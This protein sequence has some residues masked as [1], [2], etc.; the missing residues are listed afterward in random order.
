MR[1]H[2][3][4]L[5]FLILQCA[6]CFPA[7]YAQQIQKIFVNPK[8]PAVLKQSAFIDSVMLVPFE[9]VDGLRAETVEVRETKD[10]FMLFDF[11]L[12]CLYIFS[13]TGAFVK[14][15]NFKTTVGEAYPHYNRQTNQVVFFTTNGHYTLTARDKIKILL[16]WDNKRNL[17]YYNKYLIDLGDSSFPI[18]KTKPDKFDLVDGEPIFDHDFFQTQ[19]STSP[20]FKDS[21]G[22]EVSVYRNGTLHKNYFPYNRVNEPAFLFYEEWV[23]VS[24]AAPNSA[25]IARPYRDTIYRL[26]NDSLYPVYQVVLPLENSIPS[27]YFSK[28]FKTR[29]DKENFGRNNGWMFHEIQAV[30]ETPRFL[31]LSLTFFSHNESV[32]YDKLTHTAYN[33][34]KVAADTTQYNL[35][36]WPYHS[37][38]Y[39]SR[40]CH[41]TSRDYLAGFFR[42]HPTVKMPEKIAGMLH[43]DAAKNTPVLIKFKLKD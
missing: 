9:P 20:L 17:K 5:F 28:P 2:G 22:Y 39:A 7:L 8:N 30:Y 34:S 38:Q 15:I 10:Y 41:L 11:N 18:K 3:F 40:F 12:G 24:E 25:Y 37:E 43:D 16:D 6:G 21:V 27:S 42:E 14:K 19:I 33:R 31:L 29:T 36:L 26:E 13:K 1:K 4:S 23:A 32:I 35:T